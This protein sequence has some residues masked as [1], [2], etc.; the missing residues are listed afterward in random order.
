MQREAMLA[1]LLVRHRIA[2][3]MALSPALRPTW[4]RCLFLTAAFWAASISSWRSMMLHFF[5]TGI[6]EVMLLSVMAGA[7]TEKPHD[8]PW[9]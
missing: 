2:A 7:P 9:A 1:A 3:K 8:D 4:L 6:V 5:G